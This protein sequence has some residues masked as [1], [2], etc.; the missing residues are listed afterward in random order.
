MVFGGEKRTHTLSLPLMAL[1]TT[2]RT[3][4][5]DSSNNTDYLYHLRVQTRSAERRRRSFC[6]VMG[7]CEWRKL[8]SGMLICSSSYYVKL[9]FSSAAAHLITSPDNP[10]NAFI[11]SSGVGAGNAMWRQWAFRCATC[12]NCVCVSNGKR[13]SAPRPWTSSSS[14]MVRTAWGR[15]A[16]RGPN[17]T[18]SNCVRRLTSDWTRFVFYCSSPFFL[19]LSCQSLLMWLS[20]RCGSAWFSLAPPLG[21]NSAWTR[22]PPNRSWR[23]TWRRFPTGVSLLLS[24]LQMSNV[25]CKTHRKICYTVHTFLRWLYKNKLIGT[26]HMISSQEWDIQCANDPEMSILMCI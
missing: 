24:H 12:L 1:S 22:T 2:S 10:H 7:F 8:S 15:A 26:F 19:T 18:P 5:H 17:T 23:S 20:N 21:W 13:C 6:S 14:W 3:F 9:L 11:C 4:Y 16:S 25:E